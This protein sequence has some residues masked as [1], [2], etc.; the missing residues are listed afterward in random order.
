[1]G[2]DFSKVVSIVKGGLGNQLFIYAAG[3]AF[4]ERNDAKHYLDAKRGYVDDSY[5]RKFLLDR[6]PI[7]LTLM[8]EA[9]RIAP[10]LKHY[11]HKVYRSLNKV[12]PLDQRFYYAENHGMTP[13]VF[14]TL[15]PKRKLV[16]LNGNWNNELYFSEYS[17]LIRK[18]L[19]VPE[20]SDDTIQSLG[21][22]LLA[23]SESVFIHVRRIRYHTKLSLDYYK[24]AIQLVANELNKPEFVVF[25]DDMDWAKENFPKKHKFKWVEGNLDD[26]MVD[27]W[28]MTCCRHAIIANS[29]FSWWG[30]WLGEAERSKRIIYAPES[31][32]WH[33]RAA[34]S[35]RTLAF[36]V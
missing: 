23:N 33:M 9:L 21:R 13:E 16:H 11:K 8:P 6:F 19:H 17:E 26:E 4:A 7:D 2:E 28:L 5:G 20:P 22:S 35:W 10:T 36:E 14:W 29:G 18:S 27:F 1:M 31:P 3:R 12:L 34:R 25:S 24:N 32:D 30:A 15:Q